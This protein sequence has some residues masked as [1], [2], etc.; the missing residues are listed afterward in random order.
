MPSL[1]FCIV[2]HCCLCKC[3]KINRVSE[4]AFNNRQKRAQLLML[5]DFRW[6]IHFE[7]LFFYFST[8][9]VLSSDA[10]PQDGDARGASVNKSEVVS[11]TR[12]GGGC[13]I[14]DRPTQL[15]CI[16]R[17]ILPLD[18]SGPYTRGMTD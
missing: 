17:F 15:I 10:V 6:I 7:G 18:T 9:S 16:W 8:N 4:Q 12:V 13:V 1:S 3:L 2:V 5:P 11:L 14:I